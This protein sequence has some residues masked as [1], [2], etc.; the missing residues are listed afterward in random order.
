M[1][2][3]RIRIVTSKISMCGVAWR[4]TRQDAQNTLIWFAVKKDLVFVRT[5]VSRRELQQR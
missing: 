2:G 5:S 4:V 3:A 1:K